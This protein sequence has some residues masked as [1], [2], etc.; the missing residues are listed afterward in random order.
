MG[1]KGEN[2]RQRRDGRWEARCIS[3]Y[4]EANRAVYH[5]IYGSTY[6]EARRK[7]TEY[8]KQLKSQKNEEETERKE[9][10]YSML[11][12]RFLTDIETKVKLSTLNRY[13]EIIQN[14]IKPNLG[15]FLLSDINSLQID[16]FTKDRLA[17]GRVDGAGGLSARTVRSIL[18]LVRLTISYGDECG[19]AVSE[20]YRIHTPRTTQTGAKAFTLEDQK[21]LEAWLND[22]PGRISLGIWLSLYTGLRIG[23]VCALQWKEIDLKEKQI[24]ISQ[25]AQRVTQENENDRQTT[26]IVTDPKSDCS[27]RTIPL[28]SFLCEMLEQNSQSDEVYLLTGSKELMEPR[29]YYRNYRSILKDLHLE[30]YNYHS[31]RHTFA[32]RCVT[33]G[34]DAKSLSE[35]MGHSS[36]RVTME[37][38]VH[39]TTQTKRNYMN[40]LSQ[41]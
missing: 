20:T 24:T 2:I 38:Y 3:G 4:D 21:V 25:T 28:P 9:I 30:K 22:N 26:V 40:R 41:I 34:F 27:N 32:S 12:D 14:H 39:P 13:K 6:S 33:A 11:L 5:S 23:E 16:R 10:R 8:L 35:I 31:L 15:S 29:T 19:Y 36:P 1:R 17:N 37:N 7:R 18:S